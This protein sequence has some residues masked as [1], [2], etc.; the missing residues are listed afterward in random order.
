L[1]KEILS[2]TLRSLNV[3]DPPGKEQFLIPLDEAQFKP[4]PI[5]Q[6]RHWLED[7]R[8]SGAAEPEAMAL[9]SATSRGIPSVRTV[10]LRGFDHRGFV[11]FTYYASRKGRELDANPAA[12]LLF[13]WP[14]VDRQVR[15][16]GRV[17][18]VTAEESDVYFESR[19][20]GSRLSAIASP[21]SQ[22]IEN[23]AELE[24]RVQELLASYRHAPAT[25]RRPVSWGG[26]RVIPSVIEFWQS[27]PHRLHDR[28]RYR[29]DARGDWLIERLAP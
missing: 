15:I 13:Y 2:D 19:P 27:G 24:Q 3:S 28:L 12:A 6:F 16:E 22:V 18:R 29:K 11:F 9:A 23:R 14:E 25:I 26:Y 4:D 8:R 1:K 21:Q 20:V 17:E 10:M 7:V 5:D